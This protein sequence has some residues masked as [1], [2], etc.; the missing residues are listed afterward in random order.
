MRRRLPILGL[1]LAGVAITAMPAAAQNAP[2]QAQVYD[3][4]PPPDSAYVR[5]VNGLGE[6]VAVR[7]GFMPPLRLGTGTQDRVTPYSVAEK[8]GTRELTIEASAQGRNAR[9]TLRAASGSFNTVLLHRAPDGSITG[10][11][12]V[13]LADFNRARA[14]LSFYNLAPNCGTA[15]LQIA[16]PGPSVFDQVA[17]GTAKSRSVNPVTAQLLAGCGEGASA[18]NFPLENTEAGGMYSIWLMRPDGQALTSF[19][20]RDTTTPW[21]R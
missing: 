13:D 21:R 6:E 17:F 11:P 5:F 9:I 3:P 12:V 15:S 14:K 8:V 7:P 4:Q 10:T 2:S 20:T 1:L 19:V 16:P 18:P